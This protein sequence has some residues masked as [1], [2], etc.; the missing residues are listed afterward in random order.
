MFTG[1]KAISIL[2]NEIGQYDPHESSH[3]QYFNKDI[4]YKNNKLKGY[5]GFGDSSSRLL[6]IQNFLHYLFQYPFRKVGVNY[7]NFRKY[8]KYARKISIKQKRC[9]DINC[10][11][12]TLTL[13]YLNKNKLEIKDFLKNEPICCIIGDGFGFMTSLLIELKLTRKI[14]LINLSKVL[15][16]DLIYLKKTLGENIFNSRVHLVKN[17]NDLN[18]VEKINLGSNDIKIIA[19]EA[20]NYDLIQYCN[21]NF[22]MNIHSMHEM[23]HNII[24]KYFNFIRRSKADQILFYCCN[25]VNKKL[26]DGTELKFDEYNWK[27]NDNVIFDEICPLWN[28]KTYMSKPPFYIN[29]DGKNKHRLVF[30]S[31][32]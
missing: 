4:E 22:V 1:N 10:L 26:F 6:G 13:S 24:E 18:E 8:E 28:Q 15:L 11:R 30:L 16:I 32:I 7:K 29:Y 20:K 2:T 14:Y 19:I 21:F 5:R 9:Y 31:K 27:H 23:N 12:Q 17:T 25:R 3:W